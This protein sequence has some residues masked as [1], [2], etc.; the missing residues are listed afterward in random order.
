MSRAEMFVPGVTARRVAW[1]LMT[2]G[3]AAAAAGAALIPQRTWADLLLNGFFTIAL[4]LGGM[5]FLALH[6]LSSA[7]I[8]ASGI[9]RMPPLHAAPDR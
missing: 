2:V 9:R 1:A 6:Y 8:S 5:V 4:A 3:A 7:A